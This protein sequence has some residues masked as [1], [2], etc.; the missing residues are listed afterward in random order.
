MLKDILT[1]LTIALF[2]TT[3]GYAQ[4]I[5][6]PCGTVGELK[7][8]VEAR[9]LQNLSTLAEEPL[10]F[11]DVQY[12]PIR[13][14]LVGKSDGAGRVTEQRVLDQLCILNQDY[15][16]MDIQFYLKGNDFFNYINNTTVY[17]NHANAINTFM[18]FQRDNGAINVYIVNDATPPGDQSLG[19]TLG[20]YY[21]IVGKDWVVVRKDEVGDLKSTLPHEIGH[22]FSL[23]HPHNGWDA[24]PWSTQIGNP[25]PSIS[26]GQVPTERADGSN[27]ETA[28]DYLCD[29]PADYNGFG[30]GD[31]DYQGGAQ[32]PTGV[33]ID[34][35][36]RLFM[37]YYLNC[38]RDEYFFSD[39]QQDMVLTDLASGQRNYIRPP[40]TPSPE[41]TEAA[42]PQEPSEGEITP[43]FGNVYFEWSE[44]PNATGYLL[45][46]ARNS[47]FTITPHRV[48]TSNTSV[49][50]SDI[51]TADRKYYWRVRPFNDL[52]SCV[53]F[54]EPVSFTTGTVQTAANE[55]EM[56]NSWSVNPN[57][58]A[59]EAQ[60]NVQVNAA[61]AFE[62]NVTLHSI[63]GALV[64]EVGQKNFIAGENNFLL[65]TNRLNSGVYFISIQTDGGRINKRLIVT[66]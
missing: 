40:Y 56:V 8:M 51:F 14:H 12:I 65:A 52:Y 63:N 22:F 18:T 30:W 1:F 59:T 49:N 38:N 57:P 16:P 33:E 61:T 45:E 54:S 3:F 7:D 35:E 41:V 24:T 19:T 15:A 25:A 37:G 5:I 29:T 26:P 53:D 55:L 34:P 50:I 21:P 9:A 46:V 62:G 27:C 17:D 4:E 10:E 32:D 47:T 64:Q 44:V 66:K 23:L 31:C 2:T 28:G 48:V 39:M 6:N 43:S 60:V 20:Y 13:F 42:A 11:R 36:E 58:V